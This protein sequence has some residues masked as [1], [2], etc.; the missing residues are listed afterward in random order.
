MLDPNFVH[1]PGILAEFMTRFSVRLEA[2]M[3]K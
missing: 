2:I 1:D 3:V